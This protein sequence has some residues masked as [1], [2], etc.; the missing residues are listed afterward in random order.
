MSGVLGTAPP[1]PGRG[2]RTGRHTLTGMA[3]V[4]P[5]GEQWTLRH[6]D[7]RAVV[8]ELGGGLREY[9]VDGVDVVAGY[10]ADEL[11]DIGRGQQLAPWPNRV[12]DARYA[13][14][15]TEH[16]LAATEPDRG[17]ALHGLVRWSA[18]QLAER[19]E[20]R[21][22]VT[23]RLFPQPGWPGLLDL[24]TTYRLAPDGLAVHV[25]AGNPGAV[26]VPFGYGAHPYLCVGATR[27]DDVVVEVPATQY[28]PLD[29]DRLLPGALAEVAGTRFDLRG[30]SSLA[31]RALDT[32]FTGLDR[33]TDGRWR[34][35]VGAGDRTA[36]VWGDAA[37]GWVQLYSG[38]AA[39]EV[40]AARGVAVEPMS[41]PPDALRT[42]TDLVVLAPGQSW[43]GSWGIARV[44]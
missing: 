32:A 35:R 39:D 4:G 20:D 26:A 18:W 31:G 23:H 1:E 8:V 21:L 6:G 34:V 15:G 11:P 10:R 27:Y 9:T 13:F 37:F 29:P 19:T 33:G 2:G 41:C 40:R 44:R 42:G 43:Q 22:T 16:R 3:Q 24:R 38:A 5:T 30:A 12:G 17:N 36:L 28:L 14:D 25:E 7:Q